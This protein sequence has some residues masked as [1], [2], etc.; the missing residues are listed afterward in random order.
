MKVFRYV[1]IDARGRA[2]RGVQ[3]AESEQDLGNRLAR[4]GLELLRAR[5]ASPRFRRA[6][7]SLATRDLVNVLIHVRTLSAAGV[8]LIEALEDL[9]DA[10]DSAAVHGFAADVL[11]RIMAGATFSQALAQSPWPVDEVVVSL[12]RTGEVTGQL[13]QVLAEIVDNLKW[14]DELNAQTR[15]LLRAPAVTGTVVLIAVVF[16]MI[17]LVPQLL[18]FIRGLGGEL[19]PQTM[20]LMWTSATLRSHGYLL[21]VVPIAAAFL[22]KTAARRSP[23]LRERLDGWKLRARPVGP[24][25]K[26]ILLARFAT[27]FALMYRSG[28]P[29]LEALGY[30]RGLSGNFAYQRAIERA[31]EQIAH[32][33]KI[34]DAFAAVQ[35]F[36]PLVVR[37]LR[38]GENTGGLDESLGHVS[39][40]Y[41]REVDEAIDRIQGAI[42]PTLTVFLGLMVAW[43]LSSVILPIYDVIAKV[44]F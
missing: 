13:P 30:C 44:K 12:V 40:F 29:V 17:Y 37:M 22:L 2:V 7:R 23:A 25:L 35:M 1:A 34:S 16:L 6:P 10:S 9:R 4:L 20:A 43:I 36:P 18:T 14:I 5:E 11:D 41:R 27:S 8:P 19:P 42:Q 15:S 32:G 31:Q 38:I 21:V 26:K 39:Y 33:T 3:N 24:I 28:V